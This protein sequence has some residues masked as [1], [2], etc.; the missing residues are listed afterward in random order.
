MDRKTPSPQ[1]HLLGHARRGIGAA[2][3][4]LFIVGEVAGAGVL[5]IP[6]AMKFTGWSAGVLLIVLTCVA[7]SYCGV[8]LGRCWLI[9]E[10]RDPSLKSVKTRNAYA[11]IGEKA[12]GKT[13]YIASM[14]TQVIQ[15]F[16]GAVV[17]LLLSAEMM[18]I[19]V[20]PLIQSYISFTFCQWVVISGL[21][22]LPFSFFGS[23][24]DFSPIAF[25]AMTST[26][27]AAVLIVIACI[28]SPAP[29]V[30]SSPG[31]LI[32][33]LT[34]LLG[35]GNINFSFSG[36]SCM[37]TIQN[38]M[39]NKKSFSVSVITAY[40]ILILIYLPVS[41]VGY[42][43]FGNN[44]QSNIIRNLPPSLLTTTI[45]ALITGHVFC[46][47]L[48]LLNPVN[49][50]LENFLTIQHSFNR[51]RCLSR[52]GMTLMAVFVALSV[53]KFG[54]LLN[55]VGASAVVFQCFILPAFFYFRLNKEQALT[56]TQRF[57]LFAI[58]TV[59]LAAGIASSGSAMFDL[60]DPAAFT[61]P[62]YIRDCD[63]SD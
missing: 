63:L 27:L 53:P 21:I 11:L 25:F 43:R 6:E 61:M 33:P 37:P 30:F 58:M 49:L 47:Y 59:A 32:S 38:D 16:G 29:E 34:L 13:G 36:A 41:A 28:T 15:L 9:L 45:Q 17:Q 14:I 12:F 7:A 42:Y 8:L 55:L 23:P 60:L 3:A 39:R 20:Q 1:D 19:L 10:S 2:T 35:I 31:F 40:I 57:S 51:C 50:N 18:H 56:A 54:K 5:A 44:I 4:S 52:I 24:A 62:C 46:A 22:L 48:I 26:S